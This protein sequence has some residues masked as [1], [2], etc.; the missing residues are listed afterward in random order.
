MCLDRDANPDLPEIKHL[1]PKFGQYNYVQPFVQQTDRA[2]Y[3]RTH[4]TVGLVQ[5]ESKPRISMKK[6]QENS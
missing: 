3:T 5:T 2:G 4:H 6:S 1:R